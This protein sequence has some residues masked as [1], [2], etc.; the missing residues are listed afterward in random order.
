METPANLTETHQNAHNLTSLTA[1]QRV[2]AQLL[3]D[4]VTIKDTAKQLKIRRE[5]VS[6]WRKRPE[7]QTEYERAIEENKKLY[8]KTREEM[9]DN[10]QHE[11]T[12]LMTDAL[13]TINLQLNHN[14]YDL[15]GRAKLALDV[16][17]F[18][19]AD[20]LFRPTNNSAMVLPWRYFVR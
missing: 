18:L 15:P 5:T 20:Q 16:L 7:F 2:A 14:Y 6:R 19:R 12:H 17:K 9:R 8:L 4:G 3:A 13:S 10:L 11:V 1:R